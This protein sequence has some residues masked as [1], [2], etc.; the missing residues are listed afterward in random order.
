MKVIALG[1]WG[2]AMSDE[3]RELGFRSFETVDPVIR[4]FDGTPWNVEEY[5]A[6]YPC[7]H[8]FKRTGWYGP[9]I[10]FTCELCGH[11]EE[12]PL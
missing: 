9:N 11:K 3:P 7:Q 2:E 10:V 5:K 1:H 8:V 6:L 12:V 4:H